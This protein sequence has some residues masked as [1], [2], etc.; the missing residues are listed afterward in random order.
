MKYFADV[1]TLEELKAAY[2]RLAMQHHPDVGGAAEVMKAINNEHDALFERLKKQHNAQVDEAH[3][4][5]ET[6]EEF[7]AIIETLLRLEGLE[8]ELCGSWLW[9]GGNTRA[10]KEAL[11]VA[12]CRWSSSK[13]LWYWRHAEDGRRWH[14]GNQTM[15]QI[16]AK[17]GSQIYRSG[18]MDELPA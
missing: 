8:V 1:R 14:K 16:R 6:P 7:R 18:H 11:K 13:K 5:T 15:G 3:R 2:R 17:C 9:I 10:H 12:G 4:T